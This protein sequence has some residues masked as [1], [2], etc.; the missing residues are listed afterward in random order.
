MTESHRGSERKTLGELTEEEIIGIITSRI[1]SEPGRGEYLKHPDDARDLLPR[2]PRILFSM[3][4]Y[5]IKSLKLPWRTYSDIGW[6]AIT[7]AVSDIIAKG[8]K[9]YACMMALGLPRSMELRLLEELLDGMVDASKYYG[10][11]ILGGDTNSSGE[12]WISISAIGFTTAKI[13]P[14]RSGLKPGDIVVATGVYGAMGYVVK[15]GFEDSSRE[16]WVITYT[17]RPKARVELGY[18]VESNYR[19]LTASMDVSDGLGYTLSELSKLSGFGIKLTD[20]PKVPSNL[21]DICGNR[22]DCIIEYSLIG[23][24]EYG[25]VMGVKPEG[26]RSVIRDLEYFNVD[27]SIIGTVVNVAP[28]VYFKDARLV[29]KRYDQFKEWA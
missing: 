22:V 29:V 8:G 14:S 5:S 28:G 4:A 7:G 11:R 18:V 13:P 23:G 6:S 12:E 1:P 10:V 20:P 27:Y 19:V 16:Q 25:V 26:V 15:H 3:D 9:P 2:A 21:V 17:K 24:E